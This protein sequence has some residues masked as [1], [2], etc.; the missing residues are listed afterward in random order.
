MRTFRIDDIS[1]DDAIQYLTYNGVGEELRGPIYD[2]VGGRMI[3]LK[4]AATD[5]SAGVPL[6]GRHPTLHLDKMAFLTTPADLKST[7][8]S[9]VEDEL[10]RVGISEHSQVNSANR[11]ATA[12][13]FSQILAKDSIRVRD[14]FLAFP[15]QDFAK[16]LLCATVFSLDMRTRRVTFQSP[17]M[18]NFCKEHPEVWRVDG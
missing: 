1:R 10:M 8:F 18:K 4:N 17:A 2:I 6:D 9:G 12:E 11:K 5:V 16:G 13:V 14:F 15:D 7:I 3:H